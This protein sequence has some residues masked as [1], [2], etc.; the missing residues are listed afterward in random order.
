MK[1]YFCFVLP[2]PTTSLALTNLRDPFPLEIIFWGMADRIADLDG[3]T[4]VLHFKR[5]IVCVSANVEIKN[6]RHRS[7]DPLLD[8]LPNE[9]KIANGNVAEV[10]GL[11]GAALFI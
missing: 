8:L 9:T 6:K 11:Q 4:D 7:L 10:I 3:Y 2:N 5:A 1:T